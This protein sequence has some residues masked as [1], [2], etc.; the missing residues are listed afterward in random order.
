MEQEIQSL[1]A[2]L[3]SGFLADLYCAY[4]HPGKIQFRIGLE[5][6]PQIKFQPETE[7]TYSLHIRDRNQ[8]HIIR[9][10]FTDSPQFDTLQ[11][12]YGRIRTLSNDEEYQAKVH[13]GMSLNQMQENLVKLIKPVVNKYLATK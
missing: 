11:R 8:N 4:D 6:C 3:D 10:I 9:T 7:D 13:N 1:L 2:Q 12:I 5:E